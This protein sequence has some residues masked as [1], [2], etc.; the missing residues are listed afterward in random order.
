M[1]RIGLRHLLENLPRYQIIGEAAAG[2]A[3]VDLARK[4]KPD[5]IIMDFSMPEIRGQ[6]TIRRILKSHPRTEILIL[7]SDES[8]GTIHDL[9]AIGVRGY[10]LKTAAAHAIVAALEALRQHLPYF[11]SKL[12]EVI[13]RRYLTGNNHAHDERSILGHLTPREREILQ[14]LTE[15]RANKEIASEL[16]IN[17]KTALA[18]RANIMHKLGVD[19]LIDL[20]RF[21]IRTGLINP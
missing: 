16:N 6:E 13:L 21:A 14:L 10:V 1:I 19:S 12:S 18:H 17:F 15:G 20:L 11:C 7:L 5:I 9:L 2:N 4:L 8:E 3:T